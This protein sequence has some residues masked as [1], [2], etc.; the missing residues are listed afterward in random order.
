MAEIKA[1]DVA[2]L[3]QMTGAGMMDCKQ[4]LT[5]TNGD[6]DQA[7][8][9]LRKKGQ[10]IASKRA[11]REATEGA[12]IAKV[13]DDHTFGVLV[14]LNCETDF[15][16]KNEDFVKKAHLFADAALAQKPNS[17]EELKNLTVEGHTIE[18]EI[19]NMTGVIGE[20]ID[21]SIYQKL[22][23]PQV[24]SYIH[25]G[26]RLATIVSFNKAVEDPQVP[27]NI[28]MQV[29]AMAP[30]SVDKDRVPKEVIEK[31]LEIGRAQAKEEGKPEAILDK[32]A[33][34]KLNK[35]F[36][37]NTLVSQEFISDHKVTV[38]EYMA[39]H[40]KELKVLDFIRY[41]LNV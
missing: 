36:K 5:E 24:V 7:I 23:A 4:A 39:Q 27:K 34:G 31:E 16:A 30:V 21:L 40:D 19:T 28:S 17:L 1:A 9:I 32:I 14:V 37:E 20:K 10:K 22:E 2:K 25:P 26:N 18:S 15:V 29:A 33:E 38:A 11:D 35:F 13:N 12:V 3:R 8:D 41:T 6:F